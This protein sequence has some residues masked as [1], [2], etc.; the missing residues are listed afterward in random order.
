M[1]GGGELEES[2]RSQ[3]GKSLSR[4]A[5][6]SCER[7]RARRTA[8]RGWQSDQLRG[9]QSP[10]MSVTQKKSSGVCAERTRV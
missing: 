7:S 4:Q 1:R 2:D 3:S 6:S 9:E 8:R 5:E 10:V